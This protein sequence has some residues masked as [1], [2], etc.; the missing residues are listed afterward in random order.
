[1][2]P[3]PLASEP[4]VM[5]AHAA[6]RDAL[7]ARGPIPGP[8]KAPQLRSGDVV[9]VL[10]AS[11][12]L[13]TL[14]GKGALDGL[15]I[16]PEM[17]EFCGK[18]LRVYRRAE[19]IVTDNV[20]IGEGESRVRSFRG[21]DVVLLEGVRCSGRRHGDC[22]RGCMIFWKESWL[23]RAGALST[24]A[25]EDPGREVSGEA[26]ELLS[27]TSPSG[28]MFCQSS[29]IVKA[30]LHLS[31]GDRLR[32]CGKSIANGNYSPWQMMGM[33]ATWVRWKIQQKIMGVYPRG[34]CET[35]PG[36]SLALQPGEMVQVKRLDEIVSTL[37]KRGK[38]RGLHFSPDMIPFCGKQLRVR[39]R[40]DNLVAEGTGEMR[41]LKNTVILEDATCNSA[42]FAFGGCTRDDLLYWREIWLRRIGGAERAKPTTQPA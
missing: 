16:M 31:G 29:E 30:T 38:N 18:E 7:P 39:S 19:Q 4:E 22:K 41:H 15:V 28:R 25:P 32:I 33:L 1:M 27:T 20:P 14:D 40:A 23:Q 13:A 36:E 12:I 6:S 8:G 10:P 2:P 3:L 17:L 34:E 24:A 37:D 21:N 5:P 42:T 9:R 35:T 26:T 11:E